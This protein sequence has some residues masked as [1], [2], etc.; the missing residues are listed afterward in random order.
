MNPVVIAAKLAKE[1]GADF[2]EELEAFLLKGFVLATPDAFLMGRPVPKGFEIQ[3]VWDNLPE[4]QEVNSW[5]VWCGCGNAGR[6]LAMAPFE[7]P[8]IGWVRQG[9]DWRET[10]W[11]STARLRARFRP[12]TGLAS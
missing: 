1:R 8:W 5:L 6:L 4:G 7:L 3:S 11:V 10:H 9:R 2:Q 12:K